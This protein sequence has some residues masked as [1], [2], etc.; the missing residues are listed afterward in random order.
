M[1]ESPAYDDFSITHGLC[2]RCESKQDNLFEGRSFDRAILLQDIFQNLF[3]AG[4][5]S[6][7][8]KAGEIVEQAMSENCRPVDI[9]MGMIAPMLYEIGE[10]WKRGAL[11]V[12]GEHSFT[13]FCEQVLDLVTR[14]ISRDA[15]SA[16]SNDAR[17]VLANAPGNTHSLAIRIL[18]L[19]LQ[20]RGVR[21]TIVGEQA[22]SKRF[23]D[24]LMCQLAADRPNFLLISMALA[25][26]R[27]GIVKVIARVKKLPQSARPKIL[28]GGYA[29]KCGMAPPIPGADLV[30][31][32]MAL[33]L[34]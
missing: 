12:E 6:D 22:D 5:R 8:T 34:R 20:S 3:A 26:Q 24:E 30:S 33:S 31:D 21:T 16:Q 9:L 18:A 4:R 25:E 1:G 23:L 10:E 14:K 2:A 19:W 13:A 28:V 7:F 32:V 15:P 17:V 11:S 29:V 27:E